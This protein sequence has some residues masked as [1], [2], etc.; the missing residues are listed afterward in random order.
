MY[1]QDNCPYMYNTDQADFD[2]DGVGD[3]CDNCWNY[4]DALRADN[5]TRNPLQLDTDRNGLGDMCEHDR[6]GDG[7]HVDSQT[8]SCWPQLLQCERDTA[9]DGQM[10]RQAK[11]TD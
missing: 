6:D 9:R 7:M 5:D 3:V 2:G 4:T 10:D 11:L 8:P 1:T